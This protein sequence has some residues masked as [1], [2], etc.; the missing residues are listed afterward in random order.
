MVAPQMPA[1]GL[2]RQAVLNHEPH[3]EGDD[4]MG[5]V[6]LGQGVIGAVGVKRCSTMGTAMNGVNQMNVLGTTGYQVADVM[7]DARA[8]VVPRGRL[9]TTGTALPPEIAT[10]PHDLGLG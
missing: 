1:R 4:A 5:V 6:S 3:R 9:L 8:L 2:V 10:T 7:Q